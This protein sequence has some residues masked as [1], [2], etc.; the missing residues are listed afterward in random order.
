MGNKVTSYKRKLDKETEIPTIKSSQETKVDPE[1]V[2]KEIKK[3]L[4]TKQLKADKAKLTALFDQCF[5]TK[6]F[7]ESFD[8]IDSDNKEVRTG[9]F[10][11]I[12]LYKLDDI[13]SRYIESKEYHTEKAGYYLLTALRYNN[14]ILAKKIL[15]TQPEKSNF[16]YVDDFHDTPLTYACY[17]N[18]SE[19]ASM[20]PIEK[21]YSLYINKQNHSELM[22]AIK[23]NMLDIVKRI[24][25]QLEANKPLIMDK[26]YIKYIDNSL[27]TACFHENLES[28]GMLLGALPYN[29]DTILRVYKSSTK[30]V[31]DVIMTYFDLDSM[32]FLIEK[33]GIEAFCQSIP[34]RIDNYLD[35]D[36]QL[37]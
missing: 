29:H 3:I 32:G 14:A 6:I 8:S 5:T 30:K 34:K 12:L 20:I 22:Y 26:T 18:Y 37:P 11:I 9:F 17:K 27:E 36:H 4:A 2:Y 19:I 28:L 16:M 10:E 31:R 35:K 33:Y 1:Q 7:A 13:I 23:Y 25:K 24:I 15:L 21:K